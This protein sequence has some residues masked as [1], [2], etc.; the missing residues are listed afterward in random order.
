ME[1]PPI[2]QYLDDTIKPWRMSNAA[3]RFSTNIAMIH[4]DKN[5]IPK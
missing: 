4:I 5:M 3:L 1:Y 2:L